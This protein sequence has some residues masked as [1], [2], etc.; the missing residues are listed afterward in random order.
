MSQLSLP[1][2]NLSWH[3]PESYDRLTYIKLASEKNPN[4]NFI[5]FD[6]DPKVSFLFGFVPIVV[7]QR[8]NPDTCLYHAHD[9][10]HGGHAV[11]RQLA[12]VDLHDGERDEL[13]F[14]YEHEE[15]Y[16]RYDCEHQEQDAD[17]QALVR[18]RAVHRVV[19]RRL[20]VVRDLRQVLAPLR[21]QLPLQHDV[22]V[23]P[24]DVLPHHVQYGRADQAVLDRA[25]EQERAGVLH[26]R[27]DDVG[28]PAL[29][30][31]M[32]ARV[33]AAPQ[34]SRRRGRHR[35][36]H[37]GR[38]G[39]RRR[40]RRRASGAGRRRRRRRRRRRSRRRRRHPRFFEHCARNTGNVSAGYL[41]TFSGGI[42]H[43]ISFYSNTARNP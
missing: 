3:P 42:Y 33:D 34:P 9:S 7:C 29:V 12:N 19:V 26:Q 20:A 25:R 22:R 38:R 1:K 10:G 5:S 39:G 35:G 40:V 16:E 21:L 41:S 31:V 6:I 37:R 8:L 27:P 18:L 14:G 43:F 23:H 24:V 32:R 17:E 30:D 11:Q 4:L 15:Q 2:K 28:S 13:R 36:R